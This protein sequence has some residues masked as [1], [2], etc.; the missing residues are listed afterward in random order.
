MGEK[1]GDG[2][3]KEEKRRKAGS[4]LSGRGRQKEKLGR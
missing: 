2:E 1:G 4:K 3:T